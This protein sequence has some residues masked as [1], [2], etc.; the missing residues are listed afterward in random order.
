MNGDFLKNFHF[1]PDGATTPADA[2][3]GFIKDE[4]AYGR[5][6]AGEPILL[7]GNA[8][9][10]L[11]GIE[12]DHISGTVDGAVPMEVRY[13]RNLKIDRFDLT[14]ETGEVKPLVRKEFPSWET[15]F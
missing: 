4:I 11:T 15:K 5:V 7:S 13:V 1:V 6:K 10:V 12:L 8:A 3:C 2:L 9:S 14:A